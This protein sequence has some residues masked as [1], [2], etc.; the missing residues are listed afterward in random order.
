MFSHQC[1]IHEGYRAG[2]IGRIVSFHAETYDRFSG[3]GLTFESKV[4]SELAAFC[5]RLDRPAN[6][7]WRAENQDGVIGGIAIDG[8]DLGGGEAHLRWFIVDPA[9]RA[10]G[11]GK[12]LLAHALGFVD[13]NPFTQTRLWTLKGLSA[14]Q[15]LYEQAGFRLEDE[16]LGDQWG[17][18]VTEQMFI[19]PNDG[20]R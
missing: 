19:R 11:V 15:H 10:S 13:Q 8:E 5:Q 16:Y 17:K 1:R 7:I 18:P 14:A 20:K 6:R 2:L 4:A 9:C 12:Q 3:F